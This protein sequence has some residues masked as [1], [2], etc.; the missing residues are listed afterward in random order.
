M[1]DGVEGPAFVDNLAGCPIQA[2][3]WLEW[4]DPTRQAD[5]VTRGLRD[6]WPTFRHE[7][8]CPIL[9]EAKGGRQELRDGQR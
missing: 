5:G 2:R 9:S 7:G 1:A 3:C 8:G 6:G 4:A